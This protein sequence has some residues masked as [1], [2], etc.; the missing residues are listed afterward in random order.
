MSENIEEIEEVEEVTE[1]ETAD[2]NPR[3]SVFVMRL[4]FDEKTALPDGETVKK[5]AEGFL[6]KTDIFAANNETV[7]I[8]CLDSTVET[9]DGNVPVMLMITACS[10]DDNS[11]LGEAERSQMWDCPD[12]D[13]ILEE[14]KYS[15]TAVDM[16]AGG[17]SS[18]DRAEL[19]MDYLSALLELFPG[20][21]A[22]LFVNSGKLFKADDIRSRSLP[23][24][25]MFTYF[26]VNIRFFK[27]QD[28]DDML[29][30]TLGMDT[31]F[32]PDLQYHFHGADPNHVVR[33]A[34]NLLCYILDN[35]CP[36]E[37]DD[38]V[39]GFDSNGKLSPSIQWRCC[40]GQSLVEP[41]REVIDI[42][43]G[44]LASGDRE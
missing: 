11:S 10:E 21:K 3:G 40:Y 8:A 42:H 1:E 23:D 36:I 5:T 31:V 18:Q 15:I 34:Y 28:T 14:C 27:V 29:V 32:L 44:E 22:V 7:G 25:S 17:L 2:E 20:C 39:D 43:M 38:T 16:L 37:D 9:A 26:A 6:G 12:H 41:S 35:N 13:K 19:E 4:L 24:G 30:D 33:H